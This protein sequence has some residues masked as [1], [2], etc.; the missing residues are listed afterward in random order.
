[1][2]T[3]CRMQNRASFAAALLFGFYGIGLAGCGYS[4]RQHMANQPR[5]NPLSPSQFFADGR[6][7]R[8]IAENTVAR[9]SLETDALTV[10]KD[11][12]AFPLPLTKELL[13]H[14]Q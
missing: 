10:P 7:A 4:L 3:R 12:N 2:F 1:M 9:G 14:G 5:E 8:P 13:Q 6:S 11:S